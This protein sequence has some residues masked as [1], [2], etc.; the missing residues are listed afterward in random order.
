MIFK[1]L[2]SI[3]L[4][5]L[6]TGVVHATPELPDNVQVFTSLEKTSFSINDKLMV[7]VTYR[8]VGNQTVSL[9]KWDTALNGG[10]TED[11]FSIE[12]NNQQI[13][14]TGIHAK[15]LAP[16][17]SDFVQLAP[18]ESVT[19]AVSLQRS[20]P[21]NFKG[22][23]T[24]AMRNSGALASKTQSPLAFNLTADRPIIE[25]KR[26]ARFQSCSASQIASTDAALTSAERI[27]NT[28]INDLRGTP[29]ALRPSALR[30]REWFGSYS[31][32]RYSQVEGGMAR[33]ASALSNQTIGF[34]C[35][36]TNQEGVNPDNTFAFV[37]PNDPYNMTLCGVFFRVP[38]DGTDSKSGTIVHEISHFNV[39]ASSDDFGSALDQSGS[40]RLANSSPTSAIRNAN[41]FEYF[42]ENTPFLQMALPADLAVVSATSSKSRPSAGQ[43]VT[44]VGVISNVGDGLASASVVGVTLSDVSG[45]VQTAET[46]V[47]P[48]DAGENFDFEINFR[49][50]DA[51]GEY[52][53]DVCVS[54]VVGESNT[55]NNCMALTAILVRES[56]TITP[57]LPLLLD[58]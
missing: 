58:D 47:S 20:Y 50:P 21:I 57:I 12:F 35:D 17:P 34:N 30:Y 51:L 31:A 24:I 36:C 48:L 10:L 18:G 39:V 1:Y 43:P 46:T 44:I 2:T 26:P 16:S 3:T 41:A 4:S 40:R 23:Y 42:A 9:L 55:N 8:N 27:A 56:V 32:G 25:A 28:A 38:R 52:T 22:Y 5:I 6:L 37:F 7:S 54:E 49:A 33:I 14:Y 29:V 15:R 11:L 13:P 53:V 45:N 19:G